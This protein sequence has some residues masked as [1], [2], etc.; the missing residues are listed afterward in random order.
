M[1]IRALKFKVPGNH[2][3][4]PRPFQGRFVDVHRLGLAMINRRTKF[5]VSRI[6]CNE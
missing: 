1:F 6:T 3:M 5:G 2:V 4:G